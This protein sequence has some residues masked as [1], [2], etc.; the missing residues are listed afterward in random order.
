MN[1][2]EFAGDHNARYRFGSA[3][4]VARFD[5]KRAG[6][7]RAGPDSLLVGFRSRIEI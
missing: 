5:L 6:M 7:F 2:H 4:F 1:G 3:G